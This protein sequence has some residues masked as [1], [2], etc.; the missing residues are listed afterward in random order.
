L[1]SVPLDPRI[2]MACDYGESYFDSFPD[3]PACIAFQGVVKNVAM[4]LGL[5]TQDVLPDE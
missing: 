3:S 1:G 5:N 4:Q 2:R